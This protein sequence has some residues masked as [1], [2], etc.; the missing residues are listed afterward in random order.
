MHDC[1]PGQARFFDALDH[2]EFDPGF[3]FRAFD[4]HIA[5]HRIAHCTRGDRAIRVDVVRLHRVAKQLERFDRVGDGGRRELACGEHV[6]TETNR[7]TLA[8]DLAN[9]GR[10]LGLDH[11]QAHGVRADIDCSES[12]HWKRSS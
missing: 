11:T 9:V 8:D 10:T 1:D 4:Q 5:V 6:A 3:T 2:I 12:R 7:S